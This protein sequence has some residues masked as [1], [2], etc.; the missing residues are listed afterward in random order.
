VGIFGYAG[1]RDSLGGETS[2]AFTEPVAQELMLGSTGVYSSIDVTAADGVSPAQ[3]R[4]R[5]QAALGSGYTVQT[6]QQVAAADSASLKQFLDIIRNFL[7]GFAGVTLFVGVFLIVNT[8]SILVAQRTHELALL[9]ALGA[10][11]GQVLRSV[12]Q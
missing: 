2:V 7:L 8:F 3:L 9:R 6:G 12:L 4:D 5:V 11:R 1:G 10:G